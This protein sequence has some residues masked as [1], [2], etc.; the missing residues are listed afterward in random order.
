MV[1]ILPQADRAVEPKVDHCHADNLP[2]YR[3]TGKTRALRN[4]A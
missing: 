3:E 2:G 4:A 1:A